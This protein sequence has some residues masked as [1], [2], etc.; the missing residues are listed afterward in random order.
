MLILEPK[1]CVC[2]CECVAAGHDRLSCPPSPTACLRQTCVQASGSVSVF[3]GVISSCPVNAPESQ[4]WNGLLPRFTDQSHIAP[5]A[6]GLP[7]ACTYMS[8]HV[9]ARP[10]ILALRLLPR[11][12]IPHTS[13]EDLYSL[14]RLGMKELKPP[15][16]AVPVRWCRVTPLGCG[17]GALAEQCVL[18][19]TACLSL[20][21]TFLGAAGSYFL[22]TV[23]PWPALQLQLCMPKTKA[24]TKAALPASTQVFFFLDESCCRLCIM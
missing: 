13:T 17:S 22:L 6:E 1:I 14:S 3:S 18:A 12:Q 16:M 23:W 11:Q 7:H 4:P 2:L 21:V 9:P 5:P 19:V 8:T 10:D 20:F 15:Q 24:L